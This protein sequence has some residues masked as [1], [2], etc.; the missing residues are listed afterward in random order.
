VSAE[1]PRRVRI[2]EVGPRDGLQ[3][4]KRAVPAAAKIAFVEALAGAGLPD[5]EVTSFV[6][7]DRVPQ[8]ADA[9]EVL[10]GIARRPGV[11]YWALVPNARGL[12]AARAAGAT[13]VAVFTAASEGFSRAN[14]GVGV[15]ESLARLSPVVA[16]AKGAAMAVRGYVST[17]FG[18]PYDGRVEPARAA[19]VSGALRD[20]GCDELSL[21]DTIG[22]AA[23]RD[24]EAALA[25]HDAAG[26]PRDV[27]A[28]H[29][30][31]TRGTALANVWE[32]L[33]QGIAAFDASAGGL[34]GCPFA[35]G[36][37]GNLATEDLVYLLDRL[38]IECGVDL[39][40]VAAASGAVGAALGARLP[41][42]ARA[43]WEA[44]RRDPA[45]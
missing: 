22:V 40:K 8:L 7:P 20:A 3:N 33:R 28:L 25:A 12:A 43:A 15:E 21:G 4:E 10:A 34:G 38:G 26:V 27:L 41:S 19:A 5:V 45:A 32:G 13:H 36:A 30:H 14:V 24:V 9:A 1:L 42:R 11:R 23:P 44:A 6:R 31:D 2:V 17:V 29:L 35:P 37:A 39:A 16:E 18:C